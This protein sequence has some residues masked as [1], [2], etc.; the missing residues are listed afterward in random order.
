M[1]AQTHKQN[2]HPKPP[3]HLYAFPRASLESFRTWRSSQ[4]RL[5]SYPLFLSPGFGPYLIVCLFSL[6]APSFRSQAGRWEVGAQPS[7]HTFHPWRL[8]ASGGSSCPQAL[9]E[10]LKPCC[11]PPAPNYSSGSG[12]RWKEGRDGISAWEKVLMGEDWEDAKLKTVHSK[13]AK[14]ETSSSV[15]LV[16]GVFTGHEAL[17]T[18]SL[19]WKHLKMPAFF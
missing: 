10:T 19:G 16:R 9:Q 6:A 7:T 3:L 12:L 17:W 14:L 18:S 11:C 5:P 4:L 13:P 15:C 2:L 8:R 1:L